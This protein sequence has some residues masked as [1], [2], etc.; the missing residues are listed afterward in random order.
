MANFLNQKE[1]VL[2]VE[3]TKHGR[4]LLGMGLLQ[5]EYCSFFDD[6][7]IYDNSY[8]GFASESNNNIK[9]RLLNES[10]TITSLNNLEDIL[11]EPLGDSDIFTD[12]APSWNLKVLNGAITLLNSSSSYH[13]KYFNFKDIQVYKS[14]EDKSNSINGLNNLSFETEEGMFINIETDYI[15]IDLEEQNIMSDVNSFEI[16]LVAFDSLKG[17][18]GAGL[19]R[20]LLFTQKINNIIDDIIYDET[21]LPSKF[22]ESAITINDVTYYFDVLVDDEIDQQLIKAKET[23]AQEQVRGTYES[24]FTGPAKDDC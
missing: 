20:K 16:E 5:P 22:A 23:T 11:L 17:G 14:L 2:K 4:K 12:Y 3:L 13:K 21:E 7:V 8:G 19:E 9:N 1:E 15:L 24:N 6:S 10:F 18:K